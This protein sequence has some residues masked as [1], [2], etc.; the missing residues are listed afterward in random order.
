M[1]RLRINS[2]WA[3]KKVRTAKSRKTAFSLRLIHSEHFLQAHF[4][5]K[6]VWRLKKVFS[7]PIKR[8]FLWILKK[9]R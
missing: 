9:K 4:S 7:A 1:W 5:N 6:I 3:V 8:V 2:A